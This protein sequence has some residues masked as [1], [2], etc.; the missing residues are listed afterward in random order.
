MPVYQFG[1]GVMWAIPTI[2]LA[3]TA[4]TNPTPVPFGILQDVSVD[5]SYN[6]KE[7]YGQYQFPVAIA[8]GTAK[9]TA[10]AK[11]AR[12][13]ASLFNQVFGETPSTGEIKA[14]FQEAGSI[15][16]TPFQ[17]TV[18]NSATWTV[19]LG[20]FYSATSLPLTRVASAPATGQY[21]VAAGVYAFAAADTGLAVKISYLYTT[22]V[23]PGVNFTINN[24]LLGLSPFFQ[25]NLSQSY[26]GKNLMAQFN[27]CIADKLTLATKLEDWNIPELDFS[28]MADD[29]NVVGK[30][31]VA[32]V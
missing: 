7:L 12:I 24:N 15:P 8:R 2:A 31:S 9:I 29:S 4:I 3:G 27:R 1:S 26:Q 10:K 6:K 17:V 22:A 11:F 23:A 19:D 20:V 28:M 13:T 16:G 14:Q 32:E 25:A 5:I 21:S 30:I 18:A